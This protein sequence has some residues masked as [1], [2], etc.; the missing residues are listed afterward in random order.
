MKDRLQVRL[1]EVGVVENVEELGSEREI[2]ILLD[3]EPLEEGEVNI[4]QLGS[5]DGVSPHI[6]EEAWNGAAQSQ[7]VRQREG[8]RIEPMLR[9]S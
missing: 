5:D 4:H 7:R 9:C 6:P 2:F 8:I 1:A 3:V